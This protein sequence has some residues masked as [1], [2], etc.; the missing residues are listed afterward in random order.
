MVANIKNGWIGYIPARLGW[1]GIVGIA[2]VVISTPTIIAEFEGIRLP[3]FVRDL[4]DLGLILGLILVAAGALLQIG[5][6]AIRDPP[7]YTR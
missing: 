3:L 7:S 2:A 4:N 6:D 1:L 5:L